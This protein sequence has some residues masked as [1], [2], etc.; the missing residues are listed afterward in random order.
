MFSND[1]HEVKSQIE[2]DGFCILKNLIPINLIKNFSS[3]IAE[4]EKDNKSFS[5]V[6]AKHE[7]RS[8]LYKLMQNITAINQ[9]ACDIDQQFKESNLY[10]IFSFKS[11]VISSG[12]LISL[13]GEDKFLNPLH[14]DI[15]A[16]LTTKFLK[17]WVP[18]TKVDDFYG[19]LAMYKGSHKL[20]YVSPS[21]KDGNDHYPNLDMSIVSDFEEIIFDFSVGDALIFN[22]L[23]FHKSVKNTSDTTRFT[24]G[25]DLYDLDFK[26]DFNDLEKYAEI[27]R[28]RTN[29]RKNNIV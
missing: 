1:I 27:S 17:L 28:A 2:N 19:S 12:L 6:F 22:P 5:G 25:I 13:G 18:M 4:I 11:P 10:D 14:Q 15:Y 20:G 7:F 3:V 23:C 29:N 16:F 8:N 9:I 26:D 24:I 21:F